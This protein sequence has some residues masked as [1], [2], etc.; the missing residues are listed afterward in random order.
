MA[1]LVQTAANVL[2]AAS[3][4]G[5]IRYVTAGG[6][7]TAGMPVYSD[8][9]D[10]NSYKPA[11]ADAQASADAVGIALNNASDGQ[12]LAVLTEGEINV[13][14]TL[15]VGTI[16]VVSTGA[17]A[18]CPAADLAAGDYVTVLGVAKTAAA[19]ELEI[20]SSGVAIPVS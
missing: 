13:G 20:N 9:D 8:A 14:A 6:T 10:S 17:G 4:R 15:V 3:A 7:V 12:P 16:Y 1:D 2:A 5:N 19:L 18:I 11:D